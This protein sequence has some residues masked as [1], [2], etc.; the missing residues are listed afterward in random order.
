M[1]SKPKYEVNLESISGNKYGTSIVFNINEE[2][3]ETTVVNYSKECFDDGDM[4]TYKMKLAGAPSPEAVKTIRRFFEAHE[5]NGVTGKAC[6]VLTDDYTII[7][8]NSNNSTE[9]ELCIPREKFH[10]KIAIVIREIL[11]NTVF[12]EPDLE[13]PDYS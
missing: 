5:V 6:L 10:G 4:L 3:V 7:R 11:S 9:C 2:I 12:E 1:K 13:V 8:G